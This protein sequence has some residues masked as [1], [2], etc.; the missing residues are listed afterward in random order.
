MQDGNDAESSLE[1]A[2][3]FSLHQA[4]TYLHRIQSLF[5]EGFT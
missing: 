3:Y 5:K 4:A 2:L 1:I